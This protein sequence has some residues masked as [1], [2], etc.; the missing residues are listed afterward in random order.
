MTIGTMEGEQQMTHSSDPD[1]LVTM[2]IRALSSGGN[3]GMSRKL[4]GRQEHRHRSLLGALPQ[5]SGEEGPQHLHR[6]F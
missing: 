5:D 2:R 4:T 6:G 1:F 3:P